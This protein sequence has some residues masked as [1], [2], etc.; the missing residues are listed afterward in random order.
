MHSICAASLGITNFDSILTFIELGGSSIT[1]M[2]LVASLS[3]H[4]PFLKSQKALLLS[5]LF[6]A[7]FS[8]FIKQVETMPKPEYVPSGSFK[9]K[10]SEIVVDETTK[11]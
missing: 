7:P 10:K 4:Y 1:A 9:H 3:E 2:Y 8:A 6:T 11:Y 5:T